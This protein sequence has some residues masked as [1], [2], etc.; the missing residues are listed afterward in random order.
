M[1]AIKCVV[2]G[3]EAVGKTC[4]LINYTTNA[5]PGEYTPTVFDNYSAKDQL[6][7]DCGIQLTKRTNA[8]KQRLA[9]LKETSKLNQPHPLLKHSVKANKIH[10]LP[11]MLAVVTLQDISHTIII[12]KM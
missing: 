11:S 7:L 8:N 9:K 1:L 10:W 2:V 12:L 5:F 4:L 6:I 3:D